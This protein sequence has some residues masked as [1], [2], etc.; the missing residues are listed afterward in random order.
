MFRPRTQCA[1]TLDEDPGGG[2]HHYDGGWTCR[3]DDVAR[4]GLRAGSIASSIAG[5]IASAVHVT[6]PRSL[7]PLFPVVKTGFCSPGPAS[8]C[9]PLA[10]TNGPPNEQGTATICQ[11][12]PGHCRHGRGGRLRPPVPRAARACTPFCRPEQA[13]PHVASHRCQKAQLVLELVR[14]G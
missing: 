1:W 3:G 4:V 8:R 5:S 11:C 7:L 9:A 12:R 13:P 14:T 2:H 6:P 10:L